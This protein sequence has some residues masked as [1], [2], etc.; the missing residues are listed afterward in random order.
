MRAV[1]GVI[2]REGVLH[3][4][5]RIRAPTLV[6]VGE[7]DTATVPAKAEQIAAAIPNAR[8]V[9]LEGSCH[10]QLARRQCRGDRELRVQDTAGPIAPIDPD[11][12]RIRPSLGARGPGHE[13]QHSD[14]RACTEFQAIPLFTTAATISGSWIAVLFA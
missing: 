4:L 8:L 7:E 6:I 9:V 12:Y 3:E 13:E 2:E 10:Q 14:D 5:G 11:A 1:A